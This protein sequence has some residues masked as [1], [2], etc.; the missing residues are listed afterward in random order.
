MHNASAMPV[1]ARDCW[2]LKESRAIHPLAFEAA[3][4]RSSTM[5]GRMGVRYHTSDEIVQRGTEAVLEDVL[6]DLNCE[7]LYLS[8]DMDVI[9]PAYAPAVGNPEPCGMAPRDVRDVIDKLA[10]KIVAL[11]I[12]EIAPAYDRGQTAILG[13]WLA[14]EFIAA[15]AAY[16]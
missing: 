4:K 11:D 6:L 1:Q 9:D 14:R 10:S 12:S 13:A 7:R 16:L 2:I 8:I 5:Q 3:Q 15:K